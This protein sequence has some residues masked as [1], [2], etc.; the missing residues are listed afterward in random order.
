MARQN[1]DIVRRF[2]DALERS[3]VAWDRSLSLVEA[4]RTGEVPPESQAALAYLSPEIEWRPIF[5]GETYRGYLEVARAWDELL[6]A[7]VGYDVELV[8]ATDLQDDR[9]FVVFDPTLEGRF[10]G[11]HVA[12]AVFAVVTLREGLIVRV[13]EY[14]DRREALEVAGLAE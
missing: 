5:S 7:T 8:D 1:A 2:Y 14:T 12:A 6:E 10:T 4:I 9:V 3:L 13:D 11:I